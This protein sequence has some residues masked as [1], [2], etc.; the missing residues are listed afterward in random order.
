MILITCC[1][2]N[3]ELVPHNEGEYICCIQLMLTPRTK[4][5]I[6]RRLNI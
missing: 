2:T 3:T 4:F 5:K 1:S 6:M